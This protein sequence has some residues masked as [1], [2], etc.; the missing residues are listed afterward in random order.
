MMSKLEVAMLG[1]VALETPDLAGSL[2]FWHEVVGL[3]ITDQ[4]EGE[5]YL[6]AW[7]EFEHHSLILIEGTEGRLHH[8]GWKARTP[9]EV[10]AFAVYLR[11]QG[12]E[13]EDVP[14][15]TEMG[16]G[17][18]IRF[19]VPTSGHPM[20]IYYDMERP[21]SPEEIRSKLK[22]QNTLARLRGVSPRR[23]DHVNLWCGQEAPDASID[24][25]C[26]HLG[27]KVREFVQLP[28]FKLGA[29]MSVTPLVHDV[30]VMF[31]GAHEG[32]RL[33]H[34]AYYLDTPQD[35]LHA[36]GTFA[37]NDIQPDLGPGMHGVT[38][39]FYSYI[40]DPASGHRLELFSGGYLIFDPAWEP[41]QWNADEIEKSLFWY[42][43]SFDPSVEPD[44]PFN[45][46]TPA[47]TSK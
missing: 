3:E 12:V 37:E 4:R 7:G 13:V 35:I 39:A 41:I 22:N 38:Q 31:D 23:I 6:R 11:E 24:W 17:K 28:D 40:R 25:L 10:D 29:W 30:A 42:G 46:T 5:V 26:E 8:V 19:F 18:A 16:Q 20:E 14:A 9:E 33:H 21:Q 45:K 43:D 44:H 1:H 34:V 27:F 36:L 15:Q 47:R 32:P 2:H